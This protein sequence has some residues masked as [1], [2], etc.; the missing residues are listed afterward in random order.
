MTILLFLLLAATSLFAQNGADRTP[1][2]ANFAGAQPTTVAAHLYS[3]VDLVADGG[4]VSSGPGVLGTDITACLNTLQANVIAKYGGGTI[5]V[6]GLVLGTTFNI[7]G[8]YAY[9]T[10]RIKGLSSLNQYYGPG[11]QI[12]QVTCTDGTKSIWI[13]PPGN[14]S[15]GWEID[16]LTMQGHPFSP[17]SSAINVG[18]CGGCFIHDLGLT[19]FGGP[20]VVTDQGSTPGL[21]SGGMIQ[22]VSVTGSTQAVT[23]Y[24]TLIG[25]INATDASTNLHVLASAG[26]TVGERITL[27]LEGEVATITAIPDSTHITATRAT[28]SPWRYDTSACGEAQHGP[29]IITSNSTPGWVANRKSSFTS[30][31]GAVRLAPGAVDWTIENSNINGNFCPLLPGCMVDTWNYDGSG[32]AWVSAISAEGGN[33]RL[34]NNFDAFAPHALYT[35]D[36]LTKITGE[37]FEFISDECVVIA[38]GLGMQMSNSHAFDCG[39]INGHVL[40]TPTVSGGAVSGISVLSGGQNLHANTQIYISAPGTGGAILTPVVSG[41]SVTGLTITNGG[42]GIDPLWASVVMSGSNG[43][44]TNAA[45][46]LTVTG[47]VITGVTMLSGGTLYTSATATVRGGRQ[48]TAHPTIVS[49]VMASV[50]I[51]DGGSMYTSAI[52]KAE[53]AVDSI[54]TYGL[55]GTYSNI[56]CDNLDPTRQSQ[57]CITDFSNNVPSPDYR[58]RYSLISTSGIVGSP[59]FKNST[60]SPSAPIMALLPN[61]G[62]TDDPFMIQRGSTPDGPQ[63]SVGLLVAKT[64]A[65]VM[66]TDKVI[67]V[68]NNSGFDIEQMSALIEKESV[69]I[70]ATTANRLVLG[71][72]SD[73]PHGAVIQGI[74]TGGALSSCV[75]IA[76]GTYPSAPAL[77]INPSQGG[78]TQAAAHVTMSGTAVSSCVVDTAGT[79]YTSATITPDDG[80]LA[81]RFGPTIPVSQSICLGSGLFW[82]GSSCHYDKPAVHAINSLIEGSGPDFRYSTLMVGGGIE[83]VGFNRGI[84]FRNTGVPFTP[85]QSFNISPNTDGLTYHQLIFGA[86]GGYWLSAKAVLATGVPISADFTVPVTAP[87]LAG[88]LTVNQ[89]A[90]NSGT[91]TLPAVQAALGISTVTPLIP[92]NNLSDVANVITARTNLGLGSAA[93]ASL[94]SLLQTSNNLSDVPNAAAARTALAA[95]SRSVVSITAV[96]AASGGTVIDIQARA[97]LV[98]VLA[99]LQTIK[100]ALNQ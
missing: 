55:S 90:D 95:V 54:V 58:N 37:R 13:S 53:G 78:G 19:N 88:K 35:A 28:C 61:G 44:G 12:P 47:G 87:T 52:A 86:G 20:A 63:L 48:A 21:N 73:C 29:Q 62:S 18:V 39:Q 96:T 100:T 68:V 97:L 27:D 92:A 60:L 46:T 34:H 89:L 45:A 25:G 6:P 75:V 32:F 30:R 57:N 83:A 76:G 65:T 7:C 11:G 5:I 85:G 4:C 43:G 33:V 26:F 49:G 23:A 93:T 56:L 72:G 64:A 14:D 99:D 36:G 66:P 3:Q 50:T 41:G 71:S 38:G 8:G 59:L 67:N 1:Y 74:V 70:C 42:S 79:L 31:M 24:T 84:V 81:G 51:D 10:I 77:F 2:I 98:Q 9:G 22:N 15:T 94:V 82:Y 80:S 69:F 17:A 16:H 91:Q 40:L